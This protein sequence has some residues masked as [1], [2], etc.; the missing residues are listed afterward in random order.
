MKLNLQG[1]CFKVKMMYCV[2]KPL[3]N[4]WDAEVN[5]IKDEIIYIENHNRN[6]LICTED[7]EYLVTAPFGTVKKLLEN[8][9]MFKYSHC[10]Y[11][12]NLKKVKSVM[13]NVVKASSKE[14][15]YELPLTKRRQ[16]EFFEAL[17]KFNA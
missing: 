8:E 2:K 12:V 4:L 16:K 7:G 11:L 15:K 6:T 14:K 3:W 17:D 10:S 1:Q 9:K 5:I 13:G